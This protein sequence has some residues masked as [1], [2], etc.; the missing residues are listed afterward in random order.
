MRHYTILKHVYQ[1]PCYVYLESFNVCCWVLVLSPHLSF[2]NAH[3]NILFW[4][5]EAIYSLSISG[6][7]IRSLSLTGNPTSTGIY[8]GHLFLKKN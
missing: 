7:I 2:S 3:L 6:I 1:F 4:K 5:K 8:G